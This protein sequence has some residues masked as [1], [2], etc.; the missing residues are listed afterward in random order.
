M[1]PSR[2]QQMQDETAR[3]TNKWVVTKPQLAFSHTGPTQ[4]VG[5]FVVSNY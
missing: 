1:S 4:T 5:P 2:E 3:Q